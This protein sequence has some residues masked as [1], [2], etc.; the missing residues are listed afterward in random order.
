LHDATDHNTTIGA[1][2]SMMTPIP[3][4]FWS[5]YDAVIST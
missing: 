5:P 1:V 3:T 2:E 4:R